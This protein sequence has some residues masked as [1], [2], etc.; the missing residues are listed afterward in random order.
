MTH[1]GY[2]GSDDY[3][4][5]APASIDPGEIATNDAG[6][7]EV[8]LNDLKTGRYRLRIA[9]QGDLSHGPSS[10]EQDLVLE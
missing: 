4:A 3:L 8:T 6:R 5:L 1:V 9:Y 10:S 2:D 7:F